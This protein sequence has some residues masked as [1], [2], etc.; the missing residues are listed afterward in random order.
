MTSEKLFEGITVLEVAK[1]LTGPFAG[2]MLANQGAEVIKI[3][4]PGGDPVRHASAQ[5]EGKSSYFW[6]VNYGKKSLELNL[7]SEE[8]LDIFYELVEEAD[9]V[10]ENF[11]PGTA[12]RLGIG[13]ED[14]REINES[15]VYCAI[16]AFGE[17]GPWRERGGY[18]LIIQG[19]S[20]IMSVTGEEDG[21]PV[22][23][24]VAITDMITAMWAAFGITGAL[25]RREQTGDGEY[26]DLAMLDAALTWLTKQ[27]GKYF[28]GEEPQRLGTRDPVM[29]PYQTFETGDGYIN[30]GCPT[31]KLWKRLVKAIGREDMLEDDR[32]ADNDTRLANVDQLQS[33]LEKTLGERKTEEWVRL[34]ADENGVP[35]APVNSVGEALHNEQTAAR[36]VIREMNHSAAGP[37]PVIEH[38]LKFKNVDHGFESHAPDLGEHNSSILRELGYSGERIAELRD[39]QI[40]SSRGE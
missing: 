40:F 14:V 27:A 24:G 32:F 15:I 20:G 18:D 5:I 34:L 9:V 35:A 33:E 29:C 31:P 4:E 3:E 21:G 25:Y 17:N 26:I 39:D 2:M 28:A 11:K 22:K 19:L 12:E 7:K 13:Y 38:P 30:I 10:I 37:N 23:V 8:G 6:T 36:G 1:N 16:S